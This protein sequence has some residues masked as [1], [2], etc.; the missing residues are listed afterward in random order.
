MSFTHLLLL[1]LL[2]H[3][4]TDFTFQSAKNAK[5]K[6]RNGFKSSYL[7]WHVLVMF[8]TSWILSFQIK[9]VFAAL[10]IALTHWLI[11]GFKPMISKSKWIGRYAF[12]IDQVLHLFF[13]V[14]TVIVYSKWIPL[15]SIIDITVSEKLLAIVLAFVFCGKTVNIFIKEIFKLFDIAV[16]NTEDLPNAGRLIGLTERWLVLL[17]VFIN[18]FAAVGFLLA[19]K[20]ILRY[21]SEQ[22]EGFNKTEY[23][24]IGTLLSFAFAIGSAVVINLYFK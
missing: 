7:K 18:Q 23:V 15:N 2:A 12:F 1:Q 14:L 17:F 21:K 13:L 8:L 19:S 11:D 24:L 6:N 20:S 5:D 9:F 4:L 3:L 22:E 16:G 10:F